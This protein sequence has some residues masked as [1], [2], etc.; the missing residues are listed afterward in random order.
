LLQH[1]FEPI[2]LNGK[3]PVLAEWQNLRPSLEDILA[4][5]KSHPA[6]VNTGILTRLTPAIDI[7]VLN[8]GVADIL[9]AWVKEMIPPGC[10]ELLR[11]GQHPK[12]AIVF[13]CNAPFPKVSSGKWVDEKGIEHQ[14]EILASG[15]QLAC[16]GEHPGT[17]QPY[18]CPGARPARTPRASL[19]LLTPEAAHALVN[20]A[21]ALFQERGWRPKREERKEPPRA[22]GFD[23]SDSEA[24]KI[25][26]ALGDRIESLCRELLPGGKV[27]G[28]NWAVG[29]INGEP[30]QS[31][32]V[33]L[34]G[35]NRGLWLDFADE[36]W[37]GDALDLIE[38]T[39]NLKTIDAMDWARSWLGW[40]Q[41]EAPREKTKKPNG[42]AQ[43]IA[44]EATS[45]AAT[46][47]AV[48]VR[49]DKMK[50]ES[51]NW[52]W[53]NRFA[54]GKLAVLAGDPGLGKS[55]ILIELA[56]LHSIG[57]EFPC[58]E[59]HAQQCESLIL[60]AEDGLRDTLIPRL[61]AAG[62]D[63]EKIHFLTGTKG[64]GADDVSL[65]DLGRDIA[66]LRKA[67]KE[68]PNIRILIIDPL[69]AYLGPIKAKENS[70]V[71]R[72]LAP[73]VKLIEETGV[74]AI[75]NNHLNKS[76]GKALYRV[77]DS[78]AFVAVGRTVHLV[79]KDADNP[80][81]RKF[82]CDKTNIGSKPLGLTYL[83]QKTWIT[84]PETGEE[85]ETSRICWGTQHIDESADEAL[86]DSAEPTHKD[87]AI[88][89]LRKILAD[90]PV[91]VA[92]IEAEAQAARVLG[93]S[94][95]ISQSKPFRTAR[96]A[97]GVVSNRAGFGRGGSWTLALPSKVPS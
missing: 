92:D 9:H 51:I 1:G 82:I 7:D 28:K 70:E 77:L 61:M 67:L 2:P 12:R 6:S 86:G 71:R 62:A 38:A 36:G 8:E 89:F 65:F 49:A 76:A 33:C 42:S 4:W 47:T 14:L 44:P 21:K 87:E 60:T 69:T 58:G 63:L 37:R 97:L 3:I 20:R 95:S 84:A 13:S 16:Y 55:T 83:V 25:A 90:G 39:K 22:N 72:V 93:A 23:R 45:E 74:L 66:A 80:D 91:P 35:E 59:G 31:L 73:L 50:S 40:P 46:R 24:H 11:F 88:D 29:N 68:H 19:P 30:G 48:L 52:A 96:D 64:K 34:V 43:P 26:T 32:K 85:I 57:G 18:A 41:R 94:Q 53:K 27:D 54:F 5:E 56:A 81:N 17:R 10:P 79:I 15:Q 75:G 78:I